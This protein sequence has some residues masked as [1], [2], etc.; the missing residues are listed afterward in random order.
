MEP[1]EGYRGYGSEW[2]IF[3]PEPDALDYALRRCGLAVRDPAAPDHAEFIHDFKEWF[4]SRS[5]C[6]RTGGEG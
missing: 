3:V 5:Y 2:G 4:Y 6:R 1:S